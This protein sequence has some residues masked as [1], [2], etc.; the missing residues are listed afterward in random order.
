M[1]VE[2]LN[3]PQCGAP[4][5]LKP[6]QTLAVCGYCNSSVRV[7]ESVMVGTAPQIT[8]VEIPTEVVD[9]VKRRLVLGLTTDA[10]DY[11]AKEAKISPEEATA[12]VKAMKDSIGDAPSLS[13]NGLVTFSV[14]ALAGIAAAIIGFSFVLDGDILIGVG[15]II[16]A[17]LFVGM[18]WYA[19]SRGLPAF[20]LEHQG[21]AAQAKILKVWLVNT[22]TVKGTTGEVQLLR[23][24]LQIQPPTGT[25]YQAEAN[26]MVSEP[27]QPKFKPGCLIKVKFDPKDPKRV[28]VTG[29]Q[30]EAN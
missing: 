24:L 5:T 15:V 8:K 28:V 30:A 14:L 21:K 18:N 11:Y 19:L 9:E 29:S 6:G 3:C 7:T 20:L 1:S 22:L 2:S 12:A 17:L 10:A 4:L 26:C 27:S 23:L 16:I 13:T 25:G